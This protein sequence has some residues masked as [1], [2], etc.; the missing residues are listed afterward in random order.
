MYKDNGTRKRYFFIAKKSITKASHLNTAV[1]VIQ[2]M[3]AD[4]TVVVAGKAMGKLS[5]VRDT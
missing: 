2:P 1:Q 5:T 3:N 4:M